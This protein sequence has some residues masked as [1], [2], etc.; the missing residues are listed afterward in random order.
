M[1]RRVWEQHL[2]GSHGPELLL[3]LLHQDRLLRQGPWEHRLVHPV[4]PVAIWS[5]ILWQHNS[6]SIKVAKAS[7]QRNL[8]MARA[9]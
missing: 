9:G 6:T 5:P 1:H 3:E 8:V 7:S 2:Q 4:H